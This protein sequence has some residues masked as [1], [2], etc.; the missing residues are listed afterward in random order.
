MKAD[1]TIYGDTKIEYRYSEA[2]GL[3]IIRKIIEFCEKYNISCGESL[4]QKD[5]GVIYSPELVSDI[6]DDV[7][8][9]KYVGDEDIF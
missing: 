1:F 5:D 3:D 9:F 4:M 7:L 8:K 6:I 2:A